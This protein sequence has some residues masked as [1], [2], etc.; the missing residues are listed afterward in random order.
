[1][2]E[3]STKTSTVG[4]VFGSAFCAAHHATSVYVAAALFI[5]GH[6]FCLH[7]AKRWAEY[8]A[9]ASAFFNRSTEFAAFI[10]WLN[11]QTDA[12]Q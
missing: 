8:R 7:H 10:N 5:D 2:T 1:M 9:D 11:N 4:A 3:P 6:S 12:G